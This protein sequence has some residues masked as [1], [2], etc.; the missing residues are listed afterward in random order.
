[1]SQKVL[2]LDYST[3]LALNGLNT[4]TLDTNYSSII[5]GTCGSEVTFAQVLFGPEVLRE[6]TSSNQKVPFLLDT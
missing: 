4:H 3:V 2:T 5:Q 1:M 6:T